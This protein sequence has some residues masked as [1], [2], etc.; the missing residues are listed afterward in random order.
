MT[1][2]IVHV[3]QRCDDARDISVMLSTV[4]SNAEIDVERR[5]V[6]RGRRT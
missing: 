2:Y 1:Y 5:K 3:R 4:S 6:R